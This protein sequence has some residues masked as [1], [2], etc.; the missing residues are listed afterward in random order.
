M[1]LRQVM[2]AS[3]AAVLAIGGSPI[4]LAQQ[5]ALGGKATDEA[6]KPYTDYSVR[7]RE[8]QSGQVF[9]TQTLSTD[10]QFSF[11]GL[12]LGQSYIVELIQPGNNNR[13]VCTEGPFS[14]NQQR[15]SVTNVNVDC[16]TNPTALWLLAAAAGLTTAGVVVA[17]DDTPA[18]P[19]GVPAT[20][21]AFS[22][23]NSR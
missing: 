19:Q 2:A 16:G 12:T 15:S 11:T 3:L 6:K 4:L 10:G 1:G 5:G 22:Q 9:G 21:G 8:P 14:L 7:L 17:G 13:V 23:S 18:P 20:F